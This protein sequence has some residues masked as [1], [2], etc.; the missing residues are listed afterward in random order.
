MI[1]IILP[2]YNEENNIKKVID[3]VLDFFYKKSFPF[4]I[5]A[6]NDGSQDGTVG[7]LNDYL[8]QK[9]IIVV[10]HAKNLGYG[11]A[12]RSGFNKARGD[13]I[14]FTDSDGQFAIE[15]INPFLEKIPLLRLVCGL[16]QEYHN[17]S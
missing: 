7:V 11:A 16:V 9:N 14:F 13:L 15:D 2:V 1:S 17:P 3:G 10:S 6:V 12:L 5:I 4:E 8:G